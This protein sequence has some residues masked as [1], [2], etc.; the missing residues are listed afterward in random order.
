MRP[1]RYHFRL[2][3]ILTFVFYGHVTAQKTNLRI[4]EVQKASRIP[5]IDGRRDDDCWI[6]T[7]WYNIDQLWLGDSYSKKDFQG[8]YKLSWSKDALYVLVEIKDDILW[9][10]HED[11]LVL[12][13]DDDCLQVFVDEDNSGGN[14]QHNYNAFAYYIALD[15]NVVNKDSKQNARFYNNHIEVKRSQKKNISLWE[16]AIHLYPDTY[17]DDKRSAPVF[18]RRNKSIGFAVAYCDNDGSKEREHFIG[19]EVVKVLDKNNGWIDAGIFG[20][21]KLVD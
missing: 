14:Y 13:W 16:M 9:D 5:I 2:T 4:T 18:L 3:L 21:I 6:N 19:S 10:Q 15:H 20:T 8:R 17:T 1:V 7:N 12:W 11:P